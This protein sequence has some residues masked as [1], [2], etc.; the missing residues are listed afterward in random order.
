MEPR[1][2]RPD[3]RLAAI[4]TLARAGVPVG[5]MIAPVVPGLNDSEIP[6]ILE[7]AAAAGARSASWVLLRL[8]QPVDQLFADWLERNFPD[9][10]ERVLG[11]IRECRDGRHVRS[12]GSVCANAVRVCTPNRLRALFDVAARKAGVGY[13]PLPTASS[14]TAVVRPLPAGWSGADSK[15]CSGGSD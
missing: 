7:R 11:R 3:K 14:L 8:P 9:R 6:A 1:A 10:K 13:R 15:C 2:A 4:E 12:R 5:I